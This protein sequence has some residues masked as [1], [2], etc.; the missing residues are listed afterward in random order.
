MAAQ[1]VELSRSSDAPAYHAEAPVPVDQRK[2]GVASGVLGLRYGTTPRPRSEALGPYDVH[3]G[4]S[5]RSMLGQRVGPAFGVGIEVGGF[6][7]GGV[8]LALDVL[9]AGIGLALPGTGFTTLTGGARLM[10]SSYGAHGLVLFPAELRTEIDLGAGWRAIAASE[11]RLSPVGR[12][13]I[14]GTDGFA[15]TL[16][17][18]WAKGRV[19]PGEEDG[20][21]EWSRGQFAGFTA[22]ELRGVRFIGFTV[23]M[24]VVSGG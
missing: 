18:G 22:W 23:G 2:V 10:V 24:H 1:D 5:S 6:A 7:P 11:L 19:R 3:V 21:K 13:T 20:W 16:A 17:F 14:P 4:V 12:G 15:M 8:D 9:P